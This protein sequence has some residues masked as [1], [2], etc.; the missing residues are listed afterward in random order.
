MTAAHGVIAILES[1]Y[2]SLDL[3]TILD[4]YADDAKL[5]AHLFGLVNANKRQIRA[6]YADLFEA[7][8]DVE[9]VT[10]CI[11]GTP[12]LVI[13]ECDVRCTARRNS[14]ALGVTRGDAVVMRGCRC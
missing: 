6:F 2:N 1:T 14:P 7:N 11:S 9:F 10:R 12:D 4:L 5:T 13:W 8:G 3:D